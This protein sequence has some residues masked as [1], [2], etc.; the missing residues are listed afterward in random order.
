[1]I[2]SAA[3][4]ETEAGRR[5]G[6]GTIKEA[7]TMGQAGNTT[8]EDCIWK[9]ETES[10]NPSIMS[11]TMYTKNTSHSQGEVLAVLALVTGLFVFKET[12]IRKEPVDSEADV[13]KF[14]TTKMQNMIQLQAKT[15][16]ELREM[17]K[18]NERLEKELHGISSSS[19]VLCDE[20]STQQGHSCEGDDI[21]AVEVDMKSP[22]WLHSSYWN[23][24]HETVVLVHGYGGTAEYLPTGILKNAYLKNGTYNVIVADWG[25][26]AKLPCYVSAV[27]NFRLAAKCLGELLTFLRN[28]GVD[29]QK[30]TCVGH[31]LGAHVCGVAANYLNF[32]MH[33]IIGLDPAR[34]LIP[35]AAK[36]KLDA[37][38]ADNVQILHTSSNYGDAKK[39]GHVDF[40]FNGGRVQPFC[41]NATDQE[42]CSH[43]RS[44]CYMAESIFS[45]SV[46]FGTKCKRRNVMTEDDPKGILN[47]IGSA[48]FVPIGQLTPNGALG[49]YCISNVEAPFCPEENKSFGSPYCCKP[50]PTSTPPPLIGR[51]EDFKMN[52]KR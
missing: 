45:H 34:P 39:S 20:N 28:S 9:M 4:T 46:R 41:A 3:V 15:S 36:S 23:P 26:L 21:R 50:S 13:K 10:C 35:N 18:S 47:R 2:S 31:S 14:V 8:R 38:D 5:I 37:G 27:H 48:H 30:T 49:T 16:T 1:M 51:E 42:L 12:Y 22:A 17:Q 19:E 40:Y 7:L 29:T 11:F 24:S 52:N 44:A 25:P 43:L 32:R 6:N 33:K